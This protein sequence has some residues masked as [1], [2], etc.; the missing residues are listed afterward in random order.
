MSPNSKWICRQFQFQFSCHLQLAQPLELWNCPRRIKRP[1]HALRSHHL[2]SVIA[3]HTSLLYTLLTFTHAKLRYKPPHPNQHRRKTARATPCIWSSSKATTTRHWLTSNALFVAWKQCLH[4]GARTL[5]LLVPPYNTK[6]GTCTQ[7]NN[8]RSRHKAA[9]H[10][11]P[12]LCT[13]NSSSYHG[14]HCSTPLPSD[15]SPCPRWL[16]S[17]PYHFH[18]KVRCYTNHNC[19]CKTLLH[20]CTYTCHTTFSPPSCAPP[21][22]VVAVCILS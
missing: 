15:A 21:L 9:S 7:P 17:T 11:V 18:T 5:H 4:S 13:P 6:V 16:C 2:R 22:Y 8:R 1:S 12:P 10:S 3:S 20:T 14:W 19:C